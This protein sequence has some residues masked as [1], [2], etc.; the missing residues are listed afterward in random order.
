DGATATGDALQ[1]ALDALSKEKGADGKR[2]PAAIILLSD[3]QTTAGRDPIGVAENAKKLRV[4]IYTVALG[5]PSGTIPGP[6]GSAVP[7]PPDPVTLKRIADI[8]GG[9]AFTVDD[10]DALNG[11]YAKLGSRIGSKK[12]TR[13]MTSG[14]AALGAVLLAASPAA[15]HTEIELDNATAGAANVTMSVTA[16]AE[17]PSAGVAK[18]AV[19]LPAGITPDQVSLVSGPSGWTLSP[20]TDG[21]QV[22][23]PALK[24]G[25]D[26]AYRIRIAK[27]P[28]TP[29]VLT[30]KTVVTYANGEA[31]SWIGAP[32]ADNPA[33]TVTLAPGT[34]APTTPTTGPTTTPAS[35]PSSTPAAAF[36]TPAAQAPTDSSGGWPA[37]ATWVIVA[38]VVVGLV[39][40]GVA[41]S[42][43]RRSA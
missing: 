39:A 31:D 37:W 6:G 9:Q 23:G 41:V 40:G 13:E 36:G 20:T 32:D 29:G 22:A 7:V 14:F 25:V 38:V 21:Y 18:V 28:D 3:G 27:L 33:P 5:T 17:N 42:R 26:A 2:A 15:A 16:E 34:A 35:A 4:P 24:Q 8:T 19:Q 10:A 12:E 43:R 11:V 1:A 30:F